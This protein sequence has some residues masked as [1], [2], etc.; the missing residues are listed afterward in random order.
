MIDCD[1]RVH[2][3]DGPA[4]VAAVVENAAPAPRRIAL[5]P[6]TDGTVH[7][8]RRR[9]LPERGWSDDGFV[10]VVPAESVLALGFASTGALDDPPVTVTDDGRVPDDAAR[11]GRSTDAK[12]TDLL[13]DLGSPLPPRDAVPDATAGPAPTPGGSTGSSS[14]DDAGPS[15]DRRPGSSRHRP[16][17]RSAVG[18]SASGSRQTPAADRNGAPEVP[19]PVTDWLDDVAARV[20]LV[21]R[22]AGD[23]D[24]DG[25]A[26]AIADAGGLAAV[27]G[28]SADVADDEVAL[29]AVA[30]RATALADACGLC[31]EVPVDAY[32]RLA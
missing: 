12:P 16:A 13:R 28:L 7:P 10:G 29:R 31:E 18:S 14:P 8:P 26:R 25:A 17:E 19:G 3:T 11:G 21:E 2:D 20:E 23:R 24:L 15:A 5:E 32:R 4:L 27:E 6:R 30:D 1:W 22:L 9:G